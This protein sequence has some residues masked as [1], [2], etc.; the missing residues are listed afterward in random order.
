MNQQ[1]AFS[2]QPV[3]ADETLVLPGHARPSANGPGA[4]G[5]GGTGQGFNGPRRFRE[6]VP[7]KSTVWSTSFAIVD[8]PATLRLAEDIIRART[9]EYIVTANLNYLMLVDRDP[10]LAEVNRGAAAVLA[11]GHP[12]VARSRLS[13]SPLPCR[14]A[15]ADLIVEL[16]NLSAEQGFKIF[17]LGAAE[18]V[19]EKASKALKQQF[20]HLMIAG[21]YSPP[22]RELNQAE[23]QDM[24]DM[25]NRSEAE[26]L[27]VAFGQPKGELWIA[28][29]LSQL[30]VPLSIQLGASFDF[31]AGTATR[32]PKFFQRCGLEW[33]YRAICDPKRLVPRYAA[34]V[35]FLFRK[36]LEDFGLRKA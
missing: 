26:I 21:T 12:I 36:L 2:Q 7:D 14:V 16:A 30:K 25:V 24:I 6:F 13:G 19:A 32:A 34:N 17:F 27:L 31:L 20:P 3:Y 18:G 1:V 23:N 5:P 11:D 10:R 4:N 33:M 35:R 8:M 29:H 9:P 22:F 15:G 28:D